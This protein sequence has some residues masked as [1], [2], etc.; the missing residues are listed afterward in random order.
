MPLS[1]IINQNLL[2]ILSRHL[3]PVD[4]LS[5]KL[6]QILVIN[7]ILVFLV[8]L[9]FQHQKNEILLINTCNDHVQS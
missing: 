8:V 5:L 7:I 1:D 4:L 6:V 3:N 2:Q 9:L